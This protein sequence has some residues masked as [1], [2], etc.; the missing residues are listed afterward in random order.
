MLEAK[1]LSRMDFRGYKDFKDNM[2][3]VVPGRFSFAVDIVDEWAAR[4]PDKR[5]LVYVTDES[6]VRTFTFAE[7]SLLSKKAAQYLLDLGIQKGDRVILLLRRRWE[8]WVAAVAL[9]RIG[10]T[11]IPASVMLTEKDIS[12]R[13]QASRARLVIALD[14]PFVTEQTSHLKDK[15]PTLIDVIQSGGDDC[16]FNLGMM[17]AEPYEGKPVIEN[18]EEM[19]IY[20]TSGTTGMPKMAVHNRTYPI[21]HIITAKYMQKV[22]NN[23]LHLTQADSGWAK[24]G[25]GNIYGQWIC[26][27]AIL[28]YDPIRFQ[29]EN[30]MKIMEK[31]KPTSLCIPPTMYRFLLRD[32]LERRHIQSIQWFSTAGEPLSPEVNREFETISGHPIHEAFGQSE[33]TPITCT[34][35]WLRVKPGSMGKPSPLY[36]VRLVDKEGKSVEPGDNGEVCIF[37]QPDETPVGLMC[38]YDVDGVLQRNYDTIYH[39]G[40]IA[41]EDEEGYYWYVSRTDDMIK[42]SGYRIGPFEIE[43]VINTHP[44]VRESAVIGRPDEIRGQVVCAVI[45]LQAGVEPSD[46]LSAEIKQYVKTNTAPYKYPRIIEY[47]P[48]LPKTTSGKIIRNVL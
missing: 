42:C 37:T 32:G 22:Q 34:F 11:V 43:S 39:T 31:C 2:K 1:Y 17:Q 27:S 23:G 7:M 15:C 10:A 18:D 4:E 47:L 25:W 3:P 16:T 20:F 35:E 38:G 12:Y 45:V 46:E 13:V 19:I 41:Y 30:L 24:F 9:N 36:D 8:Y 40:D 21:G 26:G 44:A 29:S 48:E 14:D 5:A 28:G 33:G 6:D